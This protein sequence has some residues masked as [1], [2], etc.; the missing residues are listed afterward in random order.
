MVRL[1]Q[2]PAIG[3]RYAGLERHRMIEPLAVPPAEDVHPD[4]KLI[5]AH[6]GVARDL[7]GIDV[8]QLDH[9]VAVGPGRRGGEMDDRLPRDRHRLRQHRAGEGQHVGAARHDPL[10]ADQPRLPVIVLVTHRPHRARDVRH[11]VRGVRDIVGG[12]H[13]SGGGGEADRVTRLEEQLGHRGLRGPAGQ[14]LP[15]VGAA[16]ERSD[17]GDVHRRTLEVMREER[18][19]HRAAPP[20]GGVLVPLDIAE[21]LAVVDLLPVVPRAHRQIDHVPG[22]ILGFQRTV[23]CGCTVDVLLV[24]QPVDEHHR[25]LER[26][27]AEHPV[28]RLRLPEG[29]VGRM[30]GKL[31][32]ETDLVE[33]MRLR[34]RARRP[35]A[36]RGVIFVISGPRERRRIVAGRDLLP[37][38][39]DPEPERTVVEPVVAAPAIDHRILGHRHHE[40]G[41][42]VDQ[43]HQR[44]ETVVGNPHDPDLAVRFGEM[45]HQPVDRVVGVSRI[46]GV[47]RVERRVVERRVHHIDAL[48]PVFT[49]DVLHDADV[50]AVHDHVGRIVIAGDARREIG[51]VAALPGH[52]VGIVRRAGHHDARVLR[53]LGKEDDGVEPDPVAHR[54]LDHAALV[55]EPLGRRHEFGGTFVVGLRLRGDRK[56]RA[57]CSADEPFDHHANPPCHPGLVPRPP[58]SLSR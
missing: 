20:F 28:H 50:A 46:V 48:R 25:H 11:R 21:R 30:R 27:T 6:L 57:Q 58:G 18:A 32:P 42:R 23:H 15:L 8:D 31:A 54:N 53:A 43:R 41:V 39:I 1:R 14:A 49:A 33:P 29:V 2:G 34:K 17:G 44:Q 40:R 10:V 38:V 55:V 3:E 7:I 13:R 56:K 5:A 45:L 52:S 4:R 36:H 9:P 35:G 22:G 51:V 47:R 26:I 19:E 37:D 24:P 16:L 12:L